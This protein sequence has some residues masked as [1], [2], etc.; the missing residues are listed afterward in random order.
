MTSALPDSDK[1]VYPTEWVAF[2]DTTEY[3]GLTADTFEIRSPTHFLVLNRE[4]FK[5][6][7]ERD[8]T[9]YANLIFEDWLARH[10][11]V[12]TVRDDLEAKKVLDG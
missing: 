7:V 4:G 10:N 3:R 9:V 5:L 6:Y 1:A 8:G 12:P 2:N 11:I